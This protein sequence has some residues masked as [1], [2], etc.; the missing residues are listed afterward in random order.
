MRLPPMARLV[1]NGRLTLPSSEV[2]N[3]S[4]ADRRGRRLGWAGTLGVR[5]WS[6]GAVHMMGIKPRDVEQGSG[7]TVPLVDGRT[8]GRTLCLRTT[9]TLPDELGSVP[10]YRSA[11]PTLCGESLTTVQS[12]QWRLR[13]SAR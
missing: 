8:P 12:T 3:E 1:V 9:S 2:S 5:L 6:F 13:L 11:Q 7:P 4:M 10:E